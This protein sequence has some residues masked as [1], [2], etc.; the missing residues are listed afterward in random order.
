MRK[1]IL[2][3]VAVV[4]VGLAVYFLTRKMEVPEIQYSPSSYQV[5]VETP[6][7]VNFTAR[8]EIY[9][10][11]TRRIFTAEMY[12]NQSTDV[13]IQ[14]PDPNIINVHKAEI[15]WADFFGTLP[16]KL[17]KDCLLTGTGQS[18]CNNE[19]QKLHFTL[20]DIEVSNALD[21]E[22]KPGDNLVV[23]YY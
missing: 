23:E 15:T 11:G 16:F 4:V 8:F 21:L 13:F 3:L 14:N 22:I 10:L 17:E 2:I 1:F 5:A 18:L 6:E 9:T 20:N 7:E 12:H 19:T